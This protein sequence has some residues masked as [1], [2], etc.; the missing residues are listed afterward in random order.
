M[1]RKPTLTPFLL[2]FVA[3]VAGAE[4]TRV[5]ELED[6]GRIRFTLRTYPAEAHRLD[7]AADLAPNNT[8][9]AAKLVTLHLAAGRI[10]DVSL[11]SNAPKARYERL[12]ESF[13]GWSKDDFAA[14][15][16]RY[17]A[18]QNRIV[19]EAAIG[20]RRVL[21]WY[22]RDTDYIT[23]YYFIEVD[24]KMLLDDAPSETRSKL[25]QVLEAHRSGRAQ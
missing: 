20:D 19:G 15:F 17:F 18:P 24:G 2:L 21:M 10:E 16:S 14:A 9:D 11:L 5:L 6:G 4:E 7:P 8:L 23:A 13:S 12:R 1:K 3:I 25:R 22:L